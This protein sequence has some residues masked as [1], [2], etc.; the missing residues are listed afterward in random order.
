MVK[1]RRLAISGKLVER[2]QFVERMDYRS[3]LMLHQ[4]ESSHGQKVRHHEYSCRDS[5]LPQCDSFFN[6]ADGEPASALGDQS[7][8]YRDRTVPVGIGFD[9]GHYLDVI[10]DNALDGSKIN[11]DL[12]Q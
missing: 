1:E 3:E 4:R 2:V 8:R 6:V 5:R 11:R 9:N 7:A 12:L 10:A